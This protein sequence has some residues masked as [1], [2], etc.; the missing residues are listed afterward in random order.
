MSYSYVFVLQTGKNVLYTCSIKLKVYPE[1]DQRHGIYLEPGL[2]DIRHYDTCKIMSFTGKR[3]M[4]NEDY[5][6]CPLRESVYGK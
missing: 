5:G 3:Y 6:V 1:F 4:E 2:H